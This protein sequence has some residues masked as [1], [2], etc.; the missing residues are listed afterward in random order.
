MTLAR[1]ADLPL[2]DDAEVRALAVEQ[3][4]LAVPSICARFRPGF[5][6]ALRSAPPADSFRAVAQVVVGAHPGQRAA[7][8]DAADLRLLADILERH[9]VGWAEIDA[10]LAN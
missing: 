6:R 10:A 8:D 1:A 7:A 2:P 9:D 4:R 5:D 3:A